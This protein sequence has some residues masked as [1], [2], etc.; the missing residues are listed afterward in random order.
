MDDAYPEWRGRTTAV[1]RRRLSPSALGTFLGLAASFAHQ[2]RAAAA[3]SSDQRAASTA[4]APSPS[5]R[6]R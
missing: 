2:N 6:E 4:S 3:F 1:S 5:S